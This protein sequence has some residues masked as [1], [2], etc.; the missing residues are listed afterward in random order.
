MASIFVKYLRHYGRHLDGCRDVHTDACTCG[1]AQAVSAADHEEA[2]ANASVPL[3]LWCPMCHER[4][5]DEGDTA[6][7]E[8]RT[9][10]CQRCGFLW[11]PAVVPT[12]G[13]QFLPGCKNQ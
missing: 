3:L 5:I 1:F 2:V 6:K 10:A 11:A 13:V 8:H 9:H 7:K 4:H 12:I